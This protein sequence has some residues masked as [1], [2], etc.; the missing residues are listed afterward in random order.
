[1][2]K[3]YEVGVLQ[4]KA[5]QDFNDVSRLSEA[6]ALHDAIQASDKRKLHNSPATPRIIAQ[7]ILCLILVLTE[8]P[9]A[10]VYLQNNL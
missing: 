10:G 4:A 2:I 7:Y 1:M 8:N 6:Q 9:L 3:L 5:L